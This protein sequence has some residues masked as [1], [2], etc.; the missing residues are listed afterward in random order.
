M[1]LSEGAIQKIKAG[2]L[3]DEAVNVKV[4]AASCLC[5]MRHA[6]GIECRV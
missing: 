6:V 4:L 3:A 5:A 2:D 1:K